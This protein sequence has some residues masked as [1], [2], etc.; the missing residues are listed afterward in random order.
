MSKEVLKAKTEK[1]TELATRICREKLDK[2]YAKMAK[3]AI[4][5]LARLQP[6]PL[7]R[8]RENIWAGAVVYALGQN[9]FLFY[10]S[11]KPSAT[12]EDL[13]E[14]FGCAQ[15]TLSA[16]ARQI[17]EWLNMAYLF[18]SDWQTPQMK[19]QSP[20]N[21]H[22]MVDGF[23]VSLDSLPAEYQQMVKEARARG[24][25]LEFFSK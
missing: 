1:I 24:E 13:A 18:N 23:M 14:W 12:A 16:K 21:N 15:S 22:V 5:Q 8:G 20:A 10:Q 17:R 7:L 19:E 11:G 4:A 9:N 25:D 3:K 6:S 2:E